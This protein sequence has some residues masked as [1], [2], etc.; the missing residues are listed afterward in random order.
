MGTRSSV[1]QY[2]G[3]SDKSGLR[4]SSH[5]YVSTNFSTPSSP[6]PTLS[7][8]FAKLDRVAMLLEPEVVLALLMVSSHVDPRA[9]ELV[10]Y[11]VMDRRVVGVRRKLWQTRLPTS[12]VAATSSATRT[13]SHIFAGYSVLCHANCSKQVRN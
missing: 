1:T 11:A 3:P 8:P 10:I 4:T 6:F 9:A 2:L 5:P 12:I 13:T 7:Y